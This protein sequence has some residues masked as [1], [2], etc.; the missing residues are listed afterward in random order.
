LALLQANAFHPDLLLTDVVLL[1]MSGPEIAERV[2]DL[3]P[4]IGVV[5]MSGY[6]DDHLGD[7]GVI[8]ADVAFLHKP[9]TPQELLDVVGAV[10]GEQ[11]ASEGAPDDEH[12][13]SE[14][15]TT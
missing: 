10:R 3:V 8:D 12:A 2:A 14:M 15:A 4:G 7:H 6:T 1:G 9:F 5:F 11:P 13:T